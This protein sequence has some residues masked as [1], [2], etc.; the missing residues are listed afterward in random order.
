MTK[1][2]YLI[3]SL[4]ERIIDLFNSIKEF[5]KMCRNAIKSHQFLYQNANIFH[6]NIF[7]N[8]II[9]ANEKNDR[10]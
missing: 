10:N 3:I 9:I 5:L 7:K 1:F 2:F 8:N 6:H 4:P